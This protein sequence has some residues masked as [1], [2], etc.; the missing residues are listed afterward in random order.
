MQN[1]I[2][3]YKR[4]VLHPSRTT[5]VIHGPKTG[6]D[7]Y[8]PIKLV[9]HTERA[10]HKFSKIME[11][12]EIFDVYMEVPRTSI[13]LKEVK[14]L[15]YPNKDT[16]DNFPHQILAV[17][18]PGIG[19]TVL[20][21]KIMRDWANAGVG[22]FYRGKIAFYF[23]F[24]WFN[25]NELKDMTLK[26]FLS[27]GTELSDEKFERI[28]EDITI[29]PEKA[30]LIFDGLDEFNGNV[31]YLNHLPPPNDPNICMSGIL[32]FIKLISGRLLPEATVLVTS[33]PTANELYS[34]FTFDRIVEIIGFTSDK[35]EEYVRKF[36]DSHNRSDL[37]PKIW[38]YIK[39]SSDLLNL[40]YIP[41]NC[42]IVSTILFE[43]L[44]DLDLG[45]GTS[46]LPTTPTELYQAAIA[47]FDKH[48]CRKIDGE[49][50]VEAIK[51]L[52]LLA[53]NGIVDGQLVF[54]NELFDEQMK[55]SGLLN[56]LSN[57]YSQA[58]TKFCFINLSNCTRI[59]CC[60]A[61]DRNV[62]SGKDKRVYFVSYWKW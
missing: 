33:R 2:D 31:D 52:Q 41:V 8:R 15:F 9:I 20:T 18:R 6:L 29:H 7:N 53:Y 32:L 34:R 12:H 11:R 51:K 23:K 57:P 44:S 39:S 25:S 35:I 47:H 58:Q 22:D 14:D 61:C 16:N 26:T 43:C 10:K 4:Q 49:F 28:Y 13:R 60:K 56:S 19:K 55:R 37:K 42:F 5:D 30:I 46:A 45:N 21:E 48:H 38:N 1:C 17:G 40:C 62:Y 54:H 50:S 3:F 24:R 59:S 36:C 27:Y